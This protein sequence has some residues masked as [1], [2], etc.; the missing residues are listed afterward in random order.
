MS[1][2]LDFGEKRIHEL[3]TLPTSQLRDN[4]ALMLISQDNLTRVILLSALRQSFTGN[5]AG[6]SDKFYDIKTIEDKIDGINSI[7]GDIDATL[8]GFSSKIN[9]AIADLSTL[10]QDINTRLEEFEE[11]MGILA[12]TN[13][14]AIDSIRADLTQFREDI[15]SWLDRIEEDLDAELDSV[16]TEV[17]TELNKMKAEIDYIYAYGPEVPTILP[18]GKFFLQTFNPN[19]KWEANNDVSKF[20]VYSDNDGN[21]AESPIEVLL[22][23]QQAGEKIAR[24]SLAFGGTLSSEKSDIKVTLLDDYV[25][26]SAGFDIYSG[27]TSDWSNLNE[28]LEL[29]TFVIPTTSTK[30]SI[31]IGSG[32]FEE[33]ITAI[34]NDI[35]DGIWASFTG[36]LVIPLTV[37]G[38]YLYYTNNKGERIYLTVSGSSDSNP[39]GA[40]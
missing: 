35:D 30:I 7:F 22:S 20:A 26:T 38:E 27:S 39:K 3:S 40:E 36:M 17:N 6:E 9:Q 14:T 33:P 8:S 23:I 16:K 24:I 37:D 13:Q 2:I 18:E 29:G 31:E 34:F 12:S 21:E 19:Y 11:N 32:I 1:N 5:D 25:Y 15:E 28:Y 10:E 4:E